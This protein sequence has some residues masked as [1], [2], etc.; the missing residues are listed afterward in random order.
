MTRQ[1]VHLIVAH[2]R[3][4]VIGK[5]GTIPWRLRD[6]MRFFKRTTVGHSV[7]MGR[8][9]FESIGRPLPDRLNI[10]ISRSPTFSAPGVVTV[11]SPEQALEKA[12][13]G[14]AFVIGGQQIYETY[15]PIAQTIY[16]TCVD[17]HVDGDTF[18]PE[19]SSQWQKTEI[20]RHE[21]NDDNDHAFTIYRVVR[22]P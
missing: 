10:V 16:L 6:D 15:L 3:N 5:D 17:A 1:S 12:T 9:T 8:K 11:S 18:F 22:Q 13:T 19:L 20:A 2:S 21:A 14:D 7:I 4:R